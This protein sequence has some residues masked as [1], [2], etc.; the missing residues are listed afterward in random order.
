VTDEADSILAGHSFHGESYNE[1]PRQAAYLMPG[2]GNVH[3]EAT[4]ES[5]QAQRFIDQG[6]AQLHGFW[7]YEAERSFRQAAVVDPDCAIAYWG[8]AM[9]NSENRERM[10]GFADEAQQRREQATPREQLFI[11]SVVQFARD[12]TDKGEKIERK[13]RAQRFIRDLE[14]IVEEYPE[15]IEAKAFLA[16]EIWKGARASLPIVSHVAVDALIQDVFDANPMHPAHHY[17][18]HL[19]DGHKPARASR[20]LRRAARV[21]RELPTC[22][23][24]LVTSTT[25]CTAITMRSGNKRRPPVS[26]M[27]T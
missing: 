10:K 14:K 16:V 15:D 20:A 23:T 12:E 4:T 1:G 6:V 22:G 2:M 8:M 27:P 7:Y 18:I 9:A 5:E 24:C 17:R 3:F 26:I 21:C 25:N 11:D 13:D 19:W